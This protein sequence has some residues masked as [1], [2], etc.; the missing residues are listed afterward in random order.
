MGKRDLP[1]YSQCDTYATDNSAQ[2]PMGLIANAT[3]Y[4][5]L[6]EWHS[7]RV[8]RGGHSGWVIVERDIRPDATHWGRG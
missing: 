5:H 7:E 4:G 1:L 6:I 2:D 8:R 3:G